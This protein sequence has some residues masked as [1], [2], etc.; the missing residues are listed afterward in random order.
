MARYTMT[1]V[2]GAVAV[3][4]PTSGVV[5]AGTW[6]RKRDIGSP[7]SSAGW[8]SP[9]YDPNPVDI[10]FPDSE[11]HAAAQ[12]YG[13]GVCVNSQIKNWN[14]GGSMD[15]LLLCAKVVKHNPMMPWCAALATGAFGVSCHECGD[16]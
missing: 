14:E 6:G 12:A 5:S 9:W 7:V 13:Q 1:P 4:R 8:G 10:F 3:A 11:C 15:R 16:V 2:A